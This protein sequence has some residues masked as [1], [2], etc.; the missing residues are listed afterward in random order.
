M[1]SNFDDIKTDVIVKLGI[2]TTT[3]YYTDTILDEW[4]QQAERFCTSYKKWSFTEGRVVTTYSSSTEEWDFEGYKADSFRYLKVGDK[5]F[6]KIHFEDYLIMKEETPDAPDNVYT[7][8]G[9]IVIVN[10]KTEASGTMTA[11]GQYT[12][13]P[14]DVTDLT[15]TTVFSGGEEEGNTAI[16][17]EV[18]SYA[19]TRRQRL[20]KAKVHHQ[21]AINLLDSI[22]SVIDD[23][24]YAYHT[25]KT[26]GGMF[27]RV[28]VIEGDLNDE[29]FRRDQF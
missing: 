29:L 17:E 21:N 19:M 7:D 3:A 28:D 2:S 11:Y 1:L 4:I 10:P 24:A 8:L 22:K 12:P 13:V 9:R 15:A 27:K 20:D 16:V 23:E 18:L 5:V 26:R 14:I 25:H 6:R